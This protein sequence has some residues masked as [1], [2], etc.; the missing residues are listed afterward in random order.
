VTF[1][2][3]HDAAAYLR[4]VAS[5]FEARV[6]RRIDTHEERREE[7]AAALHLEEQDLTITI[8]TVFADSSQ[9]LEALPV[10]AAEAAALFAR[11]QAR[12][13]VRYDEARRREEA[14]LHNN[15]AAGFSILR[16]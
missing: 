13:E 9:K 12:R 1:G 14:P 10:I 4:G 15:A 5:G 3:E 6:A 8:D 7:I 2:T 16:R 11:Q